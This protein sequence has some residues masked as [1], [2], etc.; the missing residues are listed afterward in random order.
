M[1]FSYSHMLL[2]AWCME[3]NTDGVTGA[4]S[5]AYAI[6]SPTPEN[7][8]S[9][10]ESYKF[11]QSGDR[12]E[13]S[14]DHSRFIHLLRKYWMSAYYVPYTHMNQPVQKEP[15]DKEK[16]KLCFQ[17]ESV[18]WWQG[19]GCL[20]IVCK[21]AMLPTGFEAESIFWFPSQSNMM[22]LTHIWEFG[23]FLIWCKLLCPP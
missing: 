23:G 21:T 20:V 18:E 13:L 4:G 16:I 15:L 6:T 9:R 3:G 10:K 1:H 11:Q 7:H 17:D 22:T 8:P 12:N 14:S 5:A 19:Q 2:S